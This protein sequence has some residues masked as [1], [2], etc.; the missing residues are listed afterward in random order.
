M[1]CWIGINIGKQLFPG[2]AA[3]C[4]SDP[5]IFKGYTPESG[6]ATSRHTPRS[7]SA[8]AVALTPCARLRITVHAAAARQ[9]GFYKQRSPNSMGVAVSVN[10]GAA[11]SFTRAL[12]CI[13]RAAER[14]PA[15]D[16]P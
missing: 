3:S 6:L 16:K 5:D 9:R 2:V 15:P 13:R 11:V 8:C 7:H 12:E 1:T 4:E 14:N 10:A